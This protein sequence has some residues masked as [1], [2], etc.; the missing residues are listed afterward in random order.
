MRTH[1]GAKPYMCQVCNKKFAGSDI[2]AKHMK[3]H[4]GKFICFN[5]I[6]KTLKSFL[7]ITF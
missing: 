3:T 2:L 1:T 4:T 5:Y 7:L 6:R